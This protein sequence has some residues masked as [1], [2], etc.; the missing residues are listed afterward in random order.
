MTQFGC[1]KYKQSAPLLARNCVCFGCCHMFK[2]THGHW[3]T[4]E[5]TWVWSADSLSS[6]VETAQLYK[7][8]TF[9]VIQ[10]VKGTLKGWGELKTEQVCTRWG[11]WKRHWRRKEDEQT[12]LLRRRTKYC[13]C[14]HAGQYT[15]CTRQFCLSTNRISVC[16]LLPSVLVLFFLFAA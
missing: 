16:T 6:S 13:S 5:G 15:E 14:L 2:S 8:K 12:G 3:G 10:L 11:I 4:L 1:A 9:C 7:G